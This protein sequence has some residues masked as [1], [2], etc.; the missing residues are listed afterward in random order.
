MISS[1]ELNEFKSI[2]EMNIELAPLTIFVGPNGA[3]KSSILEAIALM[4]QSAKK[5]RGVPEALKG[6]LVDF[7]EQ[8]TIFPR[9]S[10][11]CHMGLGFSA[12]TDG[13]T[14][15]RLV[16]REITIMAKLVEKTPALSNYVTHLKYL[17]KTFSEGQEKIL[18]KY[19]YSFNGKGTFQSH[20]FFIGEA[21]YLNETIR[22]NKRSTSPNGLTL[23]VCAHDENIFLP[24]FKI[25]DL[26]SI[27]SSE[28]SDLLRKK[29]STVFYLLS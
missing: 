1:L 12:C 13:Q 4:A 28:I 14:I 26:E 17:S 29:L 5:Y 23:N 22:N 16:E 19:K 8:K 15:K 20:R 3:G 10:E 11:G 24:S 9:G 2:K 21:T 7:G 18:L 25:F 6:D 27:L